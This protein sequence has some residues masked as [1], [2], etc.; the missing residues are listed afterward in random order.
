M[1]EKP[2]LVAV[3]DRKAYLFTCVRNAILNDA[4]TRQRS[5]AL[6][7]E[8]AWFEPPHRDPSPSKLS[9][10]QKVIADAP[11][12]LSDLVPNPKRMLDEK[13]DLSDRLRELR[14]SLQ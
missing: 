3:A 13:Q 5:V 9:V 8:V 4:K 11:H 2:N 1:I 12:Q 6:Y 10:L 7:E 14:S